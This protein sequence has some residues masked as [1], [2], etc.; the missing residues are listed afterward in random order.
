[1]T[2]PISI[3][4]NLTSGKYWFKFHYNESLAGELKNFVILNLSNLI[5]GFEDENNDDL[6]I[7]PS[8]IDVTIDD[9]DRTNFKKLVTLRNLYSKSYP[10]N[11]HSVF[12]LEIYKDV[13]TNLWF[14]GYIESLE[15]NVE[16]YTIVINFTDGI[17]RM[18]DI[19][20][21][22]PY[23][24]EY[25][26]Q[27]QL[28]TKVT[29]DNEA[30]IAYGYKQFDA[31]GAQN[32]FRIPCGLE[33]LNSDKRVN[34]L[35]L[36]IKL[37][38]LFNSDIQIDPF[39]PGFT[40]FSTKN[41]TVEIDFWNADLKNV[42]SNLLG[43]FVVI[44]KASHLELGQNELEYTNPNF[45]E[46]VYEDESSIT[47]WHNW[48]G[49]A[50]NGNLSQLL[51]KGVEDKHLNEVLKAIARNLFCCFGFEGPNKVYFRNKTN[52]NNVVNLQRLLRFEVNTAFQEIS[53]VRVKDMYGNSSHKEGQ[54]FDKGNR[55]NISIPFA[56]TDTEY[57]PNND[58]DYRLVTTDPYFYFP[59]V[60]LK[61][62]YPPKRRDLFQN[63]IAKKE[64]ELKKN[65]YCKVTVEVE[66]IVY[67]F[68]DNYKAVHEN[69]EYTF[70]PIMME[71]DLVNNT[72]K[73]TG[74]EIS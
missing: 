71:K 69:V 67:K 29:S 24:L 36:I 66:G 26:Y 70:R 60:G 59:I 58:I 4:L 50:R 22:N 47:Y 74:I 9:E 18:K 8:N 39:I 11:F 38:K 41:I 34:F 73:I 17:N 53:S 32:N 2:S 61:E 28:L 25:L 48:S 31:I 27:N 13:E 30:I 35:N 19:S 15:Q 46:V 56:F 12:Y 10:L 57:S 63:M 64:Y 68:S 33:K 42:S 21:A 55:L 54:D 7:Y 1:M 72:T 6:A 16:D 49:V 37:F 44:N 23:V 52:Y 20:I 65:P 51:H 5:Q 43:R 14:K 45:Y 40:F 3:E 62:F